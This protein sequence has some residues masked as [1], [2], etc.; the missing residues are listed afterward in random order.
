MQGHENENFLEIELNMDQVVFSIS[1]LHFP[2]P[3]ADFLPLISAEFADWQFLFPYLYKIPST[4]YFS[5]LWVD[6]S[7]QKEA[8]TATK[9][10]NTLPKKEVL[11][12]DL[13]S[14]FSSF[15]MLKFFPQLEQLVTSL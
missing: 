8:Y 7:F 11:Q 12:N 3:F 4:S 15:H 2:Y 5:S 14:N 10:N 1:Q 9:D 6:L 13:L